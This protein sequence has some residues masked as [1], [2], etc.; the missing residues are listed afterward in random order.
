M[1]SLALDHPTGPQP[2]ERAVRRSER[3]RRLIALLLMAPSVLFAVAVF[4]VPIGLF[5]FRAIENDG[6]PQR[7][8]QTTAAVQAWDGGDLPAADAFDALADEILALK[9]TPALAQLGRR[10]NYVVPGYRSLMMGTARRLDAAQ[11]ATLDAEATRA[12]LI[13]ADERWADPAFWMPLKQQSGP[14][15]TFYLETAL[16]LE[17]TPSGE[18]VSVPAERAIFID[19]FVRTFQTGI[20]TTVLCLLIGFPVAAVMARASGSVANLMLALVLIPFW[21]S[22]LVRTTA[23]VILLQNEGL[24]NKTLIFLGLVEEPMQLVFNRFGVYVAMVHVL[25]PYMILPLYSVMKGVSADHL[26]AASS[27]G[28][29]PFMVFRTVYLPL[30]MPGVAAGTALVFV[31]AIGFYVTPALVGGA[32]DQ[33]IGYFIAYFTNTSVNWGLASA[34]GAILLGLIALIY[35]VLGWAVGLDRLK[36]R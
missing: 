18:L 25:L 13:E 31:L 33:M 16:D 20:A 14:L 36:V 29:K 3:R 11:I 32:S 28:A 6:I 15:T 34:L 19:L 1:T 30:V 8:P 27:L 10:L 26:R 35:L 12:R 17:R 5:L 9:G 21:T 7:L 22:L 24:V 2:L 4:A 23:W